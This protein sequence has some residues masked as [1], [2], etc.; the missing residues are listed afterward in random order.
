LDQNALRSLVKSL[1]EVSLHLSDTA[2]ALAENAV[3]VS[4]PVKATAGVPPAP[5]GV[6]AAIAAGAPVSVP[7]AGL[8]MAPVFGVHAAP[9]ARSA[10]L[11]A[12]AVPVFAP[13]LN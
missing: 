7:P 5:P 3:P 4:V 12:S 10:P 13:V 6:L 2:I 8:A 9:V 11:V 1:S